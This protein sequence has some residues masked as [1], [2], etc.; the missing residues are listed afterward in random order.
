MTNWNAISIKTKRT[1]GT[2]NLERALAIRSSLRRL[3]GIRDAER[4]SAAGGSAIEAQPAP[5]APNPL[6]ANPLAESQPEQPITG[7]LD[8]S[9]SKKL[10]SEYTNNG[11]PRAEVSE[12]EIFEGAGLKRDDQVVGVGGLPIN[13]KKDLN[14]VLDVLREGDLVEIVIRR[15]RKFGSVLVNNG[16]VLEDAV[17]PANES[18]N[19][20]SIANDYFRSV[21]DSPTSN[22]RRS[23]GAD[24]DQSGG[25]S[26]NRL[27]QRIDQQQQTIRDLQAEIAQLRKLIEAD[28]GESNRLLAPPPRV[29]SVLE[30]D[31]DIDKNDTGKEDSEVKQDKREIPSVFDLLDTNMDK[32]KK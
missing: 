10:K 7:Q 24:V 21:L 31:R 11:L 6:V 3:V 17:A 23:S 20:R 26:D 13:N 30:K 29:D 25:S 19:S 1:Q 14:N 2:R 5:N 28:Q 22:S 15:D 9:R 8:F 18:G 32:R 12:F 4:D 16:D 27:Q